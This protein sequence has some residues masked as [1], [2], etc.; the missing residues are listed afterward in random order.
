MDVG[1]MIADNLSKLRR[2]RHMSLGQLA[3]KAGVSK[4]I[5]SQI[6]K[7]SKSNPTIN[8]I[9]KIANAL[10]VPYTQLIDTPPEEATL[11]RYGDAAAKA[12][13]SEDGKCRVYCYFPASRDNSYDLLGMELQAG[14]IYVSPGHQEK[15]QE[16]VY[17]TDGALR[18]ECNGR[19]YDLYKGDSLRFSSEEVHKY[20]SLGDAPV[21]VFMLCLYA[22]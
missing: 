18:V 11:V 15:S 10:N 16:Y 13:S 1:A 9:C 8:T 22:D 5:L 17:V 6:E 19:C 7:G 2:D 14:G 3:E 20:S 12:K 4:V 21:N